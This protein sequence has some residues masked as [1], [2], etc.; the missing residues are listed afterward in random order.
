MTRLEQLKQA[1]QKELKKL[2][3]KLSAAAAEADRGAT[4]PGA[5][6]KE[7]RRSSKLR[8]VTFWLG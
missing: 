1:G 7:P 4:G 5:S 8:A 2:E 3:Q 6:T